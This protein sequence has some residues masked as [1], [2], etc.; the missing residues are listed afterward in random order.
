MPLNKKEAKPTI[1]RQN[2]I[3]KIRVEINKKQRLKELQKSLIGQW[4]KFHVLWNDQQN[5]QTLNQNNEKAWINK[6]C[7]EN[8]SHCSRYHWN[9]HKCG[10]RN[11]MIISLDTENGFEQTSTFLHKKILWTN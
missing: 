6:H 11:H 8:K 1:N 2:E 7:R 4:N 5:A 9:A 10:D 3:I